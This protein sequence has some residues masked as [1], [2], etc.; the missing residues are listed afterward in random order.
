M[1]T[2]RHC[3]KSL[4]RMADFIG[5]MTSRLWAYIPVLADTLTDRRFALLEAHILKPALM[6]L[7]PVACQDT[8]CH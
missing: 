2:M 8:S 6:S 4:C 1:M 7:F 3:D 5:C